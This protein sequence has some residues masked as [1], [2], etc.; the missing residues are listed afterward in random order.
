MSDWEIVL[1]DPLGNVLAR[2][3]KTSGFYCTKKVNDR[4]PFRLTMPQTFDRSLFRLDG[5]VEFWRTAKDGKPE[6]FGTYLIRLPDGVQDD[7]NGNHFWYIAGYDLIDWLRRRIVAAASGSA[8]ADKTDYAD[9]MIKAIVTEAFGASAGTGRPIPFTVAA[10]LGDA[11]SITKAFSRRN[12]LTILQEICDTSR[13]GGTNLY[14]DIVPNGIGTAWTSTAIPYLFKTYTSQRGQDLTDTVFFGKE[15][16]NLSGA[17]FFTDHSDEE[18]YI[19][20]LGQQTKEARNV[21]TA[22]STTRIAAS[23]YNLCEGTAQANTQS[24]DAGVTAAANAKLA[25]ARPVKRFG[26]QLLDTGDYR[27]GVDW[28]FGDRVTAE[29]AGQQFDCEITAVSISVDG[30]GQETFD[31]RVEVD[32]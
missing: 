31:C 19:Y 18:N 27:Y 23:I 6:L 10:D 25:K 24:E 9:D 28:G 12:V 29:Y 3:D 5:L 17:Y 11:P 16:G 15:Y 32:E 14:F 20:G 2:L 4:A 21:Q 13:A 7:R 22:S 26:G 30:N 1:H 8:T